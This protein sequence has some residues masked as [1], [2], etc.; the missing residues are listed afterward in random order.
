VET[1][2][3]ISTAPPTTAPGRQ[4]AAGRQGKGPGG[5]G[6]A[7]NP[8]QQEPGKPR[9]AEVASAVNQERVESLKTLRSVNDSIEEAVE[10][11]NEALSRKSTS[12][13]IRRDEEL[14][15]YLVTIRD[16]ESGDVVREIPD[17][18]LLK[19]ARN[20]QELKGILFDETL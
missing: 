2:P 14:N 16:K 8:A 19:F 13:S 11:L 15:R 7:L 1:T 10:V 3:S 9:T 20:L 5:P 4:E 17:E 12:A 6:A 18:A